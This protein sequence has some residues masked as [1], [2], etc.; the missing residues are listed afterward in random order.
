MV[1]PEQIILRRAEAIIASFVA[2]GL[3]RIGWDENHL[4]DLS[5][6]F[7]HNTI[8]ADNSSSPGWNWGEPGFESCGLSCE[9]QPN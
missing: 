5:R 1:H 2:Y 6:G 9:A 7:V 4:T 8:T 3:S